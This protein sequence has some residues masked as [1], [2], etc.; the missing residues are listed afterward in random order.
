MDILTIV[1]KYISRSGDYKC[2]YRGGQHLFVNCPQIYPK[3]PF[4]SQIVIWNE[5]FPTRQSFARNQG[6]LQQLDESPADSRIFQM[7]VGFGFQVFFVGFHIMQTKLI[8]FEMKK[9]SMLQVFLSLF[10]SELLFVKTKQSL[11]LAL[12]FE[13]RIAP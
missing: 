4:F 13:K 11:Q 5:V 7:I 1:V 2:K 12:K 3:F 8:S 10:D 6:G 9:C